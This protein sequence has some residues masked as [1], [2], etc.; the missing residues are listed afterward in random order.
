MKPRLA[1][2]SFCVLTLATLGLVTAWP[3]HAEG[4]GN[5]GDEEELEFG[6][7]K[8][9]IEFNSSDEDVG[10]QVFVDGDPWKELVLFNANGKKI[11]D[12]AT[13][14]GVRQQGIS[15]FFFESAEPGLDEF[16]L[17]EFLARFPEGEYEFEG[18]TIEGDEIEGEATL[19]HVIPAGP[20]ITSPDQG[21][22]N[23]PVV[24]PEDCVISWQPVTQTIAGSLDLVIVGY[25]VIVEQLEP[26][27]S[28]SMH[29]P[30]STTSVTIPS[31]FFAQSGTLH[32]FE[33]LAIE[34]SDNQTITQG[35]FITTP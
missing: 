15:E 11:L 3:S 35:E 1:V 34:E 29:V 21:G 4:D 30:A 26:K 28:L 13:K 33:V 6:A 20:V 25:Q 18:E 8:L 27:R 2:C 31:E 10:M 5:D 14:R 7:V 32:A 19:T 22:E 23:P 12:V 16:P 9:F 17:E 24:D